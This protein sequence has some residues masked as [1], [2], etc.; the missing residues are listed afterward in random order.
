MREL[1][2]GIDLGTSYSCVAVVEDGI[3]KVIPNEWGDVTHASVVSFLDD[4]SAMVG[5]DA[6]KR[7]ITHP[8]TTVYSA[9]RLMGRHFFSP[10]TKRARESCTYEI[11]EGPN[12]SVKI[13]VRDRQFSIPE[14]SG[15]V[16]KEMRA[17]A[18][19]YAGRSVTKAVITVPA[20]FNDNQRQATKN[21]GKIAGLEVLRILNEPT[22]AALAYGCGQ[23]LDQTVVVYDLGGGTFDVSILRIHQDIFEVLATSGDTYLG[24]DDFDARIVNWLVQGFQQMYGVDLR[25]DP[26]VLVRVV[27]AAE[28][29]KI[30]LSE[31]EVTHIHVP[32]AHIDDNG[33][34]L[35]IN[36]QLTRNEFNAMVADLVQRTFQV[37]DEAIQSAHLTQ[38]QIDSVLMVGGASR[39]PIIRN[40]VRHYFAQEPR[41]DVDP[42]LV[43]AIGAAIHADALLDSQTATFLLDVTPQTLRLGTVGGYTEKVIEKNTSIPIDRSRTFVT[44]SDN[45]EKV[46]IRV[47]QGESRLAAECAL[48]GE[49]SISGLR[50]AARGTVRIEVTFEIDTDGIVNIS[51]RD[52]DTGLAASTT[53]NLTAGLSESEIQAARL[54]NEETKLAEKGR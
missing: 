7:I 27:Q 44:A 6:K 41:I 34:A 11:V 23:G 8:S 32:L 10:E 9:K 37:C 38:A 3:A 2:M 25:R 24:G 39:L 51:A 14:I 12:A 50:P 35:E 29:A 40:G 52:V 46:T 48:L 21:A 42:D 17:I 53:L 43:V 49:F 36:A 20:F 15:I 45:Q 33:V 22:A 5:N 31:A 13:K 47:Y 1:T 19:S 16:L 54:R 28:K 4:G 30:E 18:E 26:R